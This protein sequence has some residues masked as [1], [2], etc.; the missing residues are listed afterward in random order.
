MKKTYVRPTMT[1]VE[2]ETS[3]MLCV[4]GTQSD[5]YETEKTFAGPE[6]GGDGNGKDY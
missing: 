4:S 2:M 5:S 1:V 3:A 6:Y